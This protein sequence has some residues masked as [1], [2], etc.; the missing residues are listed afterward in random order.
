MLT[1]LEVRTGSTT[2]FV[3]LTARI[4][5]V[6]AESGMTKNGWIPVDPATLRT[7]FPGVFAVGDVTSVGTPKAGVFA[8]GAARV[9][10]QALIA[11]VQGQAPPPPYD[12]IGS[13]YI[14]FG[15][16]RVGRVEV[17]FLSAPKP[18]GSFDQ[19][20]LELVRDKSEFATSRYARWFGRV[21]Q[22]E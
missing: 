20:S 6:V 11:E 16:Q 12:G 19:P 18:T 7:Q 4:K 8:E 5:Q 13:C 10:A 14:E 22:S 2:E 17:N 15:A 1:N 9:V 21:S 3:D